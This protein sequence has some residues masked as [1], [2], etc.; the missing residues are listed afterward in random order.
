MHGHGQM[1]KSAKRYKQPKAPS[2]PYSYEAWC[3]GPIVTELARRANDKRA[4]GGMRAYVS[5][6]C[7]HGCG[8]EL[9]V[10]D[11]AR[12]LRTAVDDHRRV[13]SSLPRAARPPARGALKR[14]TLAKKTDALEAAYDVLVG[15]YEELTERRFDASY[16]PPSPPSPA[17]EQS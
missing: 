15:L 2:T 16:N 11:P 14:K 17:H 1:P 9:L 6:T 3:R 8:A 12:G 7:P 10:A 5:Y 4:V 13:C